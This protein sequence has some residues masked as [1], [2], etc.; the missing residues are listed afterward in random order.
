[1]ATARTGAVLT[2]GCLVGAVAT[3]W[4]VPGTR[5]SGTDLV[6][7]GA[8]CGVGLLG[9]FV[10]DRR[11]AERVGW[12]LLAAGFLVALGTVLDA[13]AGAVLASDPVSRL[14][15]WLLW[16]QGLLFV[17]ALVCAVPLTLLR[18]PTGALPG[19]RWAWAER[20][21]VA[22][23]VA[24]LLD[25]ALTPG[26]LS[27]NHL[28][29]NPLGVD[30]DA[31][32]AVGVA[33]GS[34]LVVSTAAAVVGLAVRWR[35]GSALQR[36]QLLW[37]LEAVAL[38]VALE[39]AAGA[40]TAAGGRLSTATGG[41]LTAVAVVLLP[42]AITAAMVRDGLYDVELLVRRSVALAVVTVVA[43]VT[44]LVVVAAIG[45][46]PS[47][48]AGSLAATVLAALV[49]LPVHTAVRHAADRRLFG[50]RGEPLQALDDLV[51]LLREQPDPATVM[52]E[53][54]AATCGAL[55][56]P[57]A[58]VEAPDGRLLGAH[59][60]PT[61]RP[62][63]LP[64][65]LAGEQVGTLLAGP[66][67]PRDGFAPVDVA[68]LTQVAAHLAAV[69][70][71]ARLTVDVQR[72]REALVLGREDERRRLR[73]DLHDGLGPTLAATTLR[74]ALAREHADPRTAAALGEVEELLD[75]A[76]AGVRRAVTGLRPPA[77]DELGLV[78]ALRSQIAVVAGA[79]VAL[80]VDLAAIPGLS[81]A[82]EAAV[83][84]VV[85]E[86]VT[87]AVRHAEASRVRVHLGPDCPAGRDGV[88][89]EVADDGRGLAGSVEGVGRRAM[90][91]RAAELG[92]TLSVT[93]GVGGCG[94]TVVVLWVPR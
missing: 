29:A 35:Q 66:R 31:L 5:V 10:A 85:V 55:R 68:L 45:S 75:A 44:Y 1:V 49:A 86:A 91:E 78:E 13:A 25:G 8:W 17:P 77:L 71:A 64:M 73:R 14:G 39:V 80:D 19:A 21:A 82:A 74:V 87:N 92:G 54:L 24:G 42:L 12:T 53:V 72:A 2:A 79:A 3:T 81:A 48:R 9:A 38:V 15:T 28:V 94:G 22:A 65:L 51:G 46:R 20:A 50:R 52:S 36:R 16:T 27:E 90:A 89:A 61:D 67:S 93:S 58:W 30:S 40:Y 4:A 60:T 23:L 56:L 33:S 7:A 83:F 37:L 88:R 69:V 62:L 43:A 18:F 6:W 84:R 76:T 34:L 47:E 63:R 26:P 59:G 57:A 32:G 41:L 70:R 11:P